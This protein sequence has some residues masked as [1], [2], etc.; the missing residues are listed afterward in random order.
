MSMFF[1][2]GTVAEIA[3]AVLALAAGTVLV[4]GILVAAAVWLSGSRPTRTARRS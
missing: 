2:L 3:L 4:L 1:L